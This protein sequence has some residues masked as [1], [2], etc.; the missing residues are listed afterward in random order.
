MKQKHLFL[1]FKECEDKVD[2]CCEGAQMTSRSSHCPAM[3]PVLTVMMYRCGDAVGYPGEHPLELPMDVW[4]MIWDKLTISELAKAAL[5]A[6]AW[7]DA[8]YER[9]AKH[10][11]AIARVT[12]PDAMPDSELSALQ[13]VFRA[14]RRHLLGRDAFSGR[15]LVPGRC[16][17]CRD[18]ICTTPR[19][20]E[21]RLAFPKGETNVDPFELAQDYLSPRWYW[22]SQCHRWCLEVNCP[23]TVSPVRLKISWRKYNASKTPKKKRARVGRE[24]QPRLQAV[25]DAAKQCEAAEQL[26][27]SGT[28]AGIPGVPGIPSQANRF[29]LLSDLGEWSEVEVVKKMCDVE[30]LLCPRSPEDCEWMQGLLLA[31]SGGSLGEPCRSGDGGAAQFPQL[32]GVLGRCMSLKLGWQGFLHESRDLVLLPIFHSVEWEKDIGEYDTDWDEET[33]GP[34]PVYAPF[35][36]NG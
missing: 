12:A 10:R 8:W 14:M 1:C 2:F 15:E 20:S 4:R 16:A 24:Q 23:N 7:R 5:V 18:G 29:D 33:D 3:V 28:I 34:Y 27:A 13:R 30:L 25:A 22:G 6:K 19:L 17:E 9:G 26:Q 36:W 21:V 11:A 31:L 35:H 32:R